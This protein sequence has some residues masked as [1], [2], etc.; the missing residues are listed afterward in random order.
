MS[1]FCIPCEIQVKQG[2]MEVCGH[3]NRC[4]YMYILAFSMVLCDV[5]HRI[6]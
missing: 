5:I 3:V 6:L 2:S 4:S 1:A